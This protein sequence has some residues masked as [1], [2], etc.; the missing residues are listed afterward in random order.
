MDPDCKLYN[1]PKT[2]IFNNEYLSQHQNSKYENKKHE[3]SNNE[4]N[5]IPDSQPYPST[6][7]IND[8]I[9]MFVFEGQGTR[10][11]TF[12]IGNNHPR[13]DQKVDDL[14]FSCLW[15]EV[16]VNRSI[17]KDCKNFEVEL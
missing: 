12:S 4:E 1:C 2:H 5:E 17:N 14:R 11:M 6:V 10:K 13:N 15:V 9:D 16:E 3:N 7:Y 8:A